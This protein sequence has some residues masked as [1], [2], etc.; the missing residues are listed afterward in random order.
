M[1]T[2]CHGELEYTSETGCQ[3]TGMNREWNVGKADIQLQFQQ[4]SEK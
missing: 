1:L 4:I 3:F 2:E